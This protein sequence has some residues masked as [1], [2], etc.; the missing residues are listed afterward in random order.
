MAHAAPDV[1]GSK[2]HPN[3]K[4][5]EGSTIVVY[6]H[7]DFNEYLVPLGKALDYDFDKKKTRYEKSEVVEGK[8]TRLTYLAPEGRS[9]LEVFRNY[10]KALEAAG[11]EILFE[12]KADEIGNE[13][14]MWSYGGIGNQLIEYSRTEPRYLAARGQKG[15]SLI[16]VALLVTP[17]EYGATPVDVK[18]GQVIV[19][20]DIVDSKV[21]DEKM[22]Q[23]KPVESS[24]MQTSIIQNGK[25]TLYGI[26][27]DTDK[28]EIKPESNGTLLEI[29]KLMK[30]DPK[31]RLLVV[32][33]TDTE[34]D[35][36]HNR[37][38]SQR[39][40]DAVVAELV[41]SHGVEQ[42]RLVAVGAAFTS[43]VAS[44]R[45]AEGRAKN[46]RVELV[47]Y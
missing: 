3:I 46:R 10:K 6:S 30:S 23:V 8:L 20:L 24:E 5:Y 39:R 45:T 27:F 17:F 35:L 28:T 13:N 18:K 21:M 37:D 29:G 43:P 15:A 9:G 40:A 14:F 4:R 41:R 32:G 22:I 2:D 34:G 42:G 44:N 47:E 1:E 19:Q 7:N 12:G 11:M 25:V 31:L 16:T 38:L 33:H 36:P 26:F